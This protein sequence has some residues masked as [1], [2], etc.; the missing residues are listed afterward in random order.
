MELVSFSCLLYNFNVKVYTFCLNCWVNTKA[1]RVCVFLQTCLSKGDGFHYPPC[2]MLNLSG[3]R[4]LIDCP[5]DLLAITIFSPVPCDVG[6][7]AYGQN[8]QNPIQKKQKL[9]RQM[10]PDDLVSAEPWYKTV[11]TLH[12]WE[13]SLIDIVLISNPMGL[14][15]LPFLTQHPR[16]C[17]KVKRFHA[18]NLFCFG[19]FLV[20]SSFLLRCRFI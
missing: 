7:E 17:A 10:T 1:L 18:C 20:L 6:F 11:K 4:I 9:E 3:F 16:F 15:G 5:L 13:V 12:L 8:D 14:L 19:V 2:H